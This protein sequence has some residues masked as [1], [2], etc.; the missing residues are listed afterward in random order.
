MI[1]RRTASHIS[2]SAA[3]SIRPEPK[4]DTSPPADRQRQA[5]A[6][7]VRRV[8]HRRQPF[9]IAGPAG[10]FL[11]VAGP[12]ELRRPNSPRSIQFLH[13][14]KFARVDDRLHHHIFQPGLPAS[15]TMLPAIVDRGRHRHGTGNMLAGFEGRDL[16]QAWSGIGELM[17][18]ASNLGIFEQFT[19]IAVAALDLES[20]GDLIELLLIALADGMEPRLR[21]PLV[22]RNKFLRRSPIR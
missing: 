2:G 22:E 18:T 11:L 9:P 5:R 3:S 12:Q 7:A 15:S 17:W 6:D 13:E 19:I 14:E 21:M 8:V 10:H 4:H 20:I 1:R 16:I